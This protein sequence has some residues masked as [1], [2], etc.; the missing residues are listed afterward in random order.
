MSGLRLVHDVLDSQLIDRHKHK[1]GRVDALTL[2]L[3]DG[4]P[5]RVATILVG[6]PVRAR[7][8]GRWAVWLSRALRR[9]G[10]IRRPGI[11]HIPFRT[12]RCL[13]DTI[14]LDVDCHDL[15]SQHV[16]DWLADHLICRIP[17][18]QGKEKEKE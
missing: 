5:P 7:R 3:R 9:V 10:G 11:D 18:S 1:I 16:E 15:E 17:G 4:R 12:M 14:E 6:G 13:G 8:V 2:E